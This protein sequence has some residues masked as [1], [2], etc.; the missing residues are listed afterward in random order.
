MLGLKKKTTAKSVSQGYRVAVLCLPEEEQ[1]LNQLASFKI[2]SSMLHSFCTEKD[3][4]FAGETEAKTP[5]RM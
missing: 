1:N 2:P 5:R 3:H 4:L